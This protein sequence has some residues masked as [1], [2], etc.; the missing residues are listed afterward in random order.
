VIPVTRVAP[1]SP[2]AP[3]PPGVPDPEVEDTGGPRRR[4]RRILLVSAVVVGALALLYAGDLLLG[5]GSVPRGVTVAGVAVGGLPLGEADQRLRAELGP[6]TTQPIPVSVGDATSEIDPVASGLAVD[7]PGTMAAAGAQ[8]FNP[9]TR[10]TSFFTERPVALVTTTDQEALNGSL[11]ELAPVVDREP[12][13][14][15]V[16]FDGI[17]PQPVDPV[18]GQRLDVAAAAGVLERDWA[19]GGTVAMPLTELPATTAGGRPPPSTSPARRARGPQ[20]AA[21]A[22]G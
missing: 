8:P 17:D 16:R 14:G 6:R 18:P 7:W 13:E 21:P 22:S 20:R 15:S 11:E 1:A 3:P 10:I 4:W 9:I 2:P 12:V 19:N 5:S